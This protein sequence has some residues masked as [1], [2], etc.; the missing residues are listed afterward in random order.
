[1]ADSVQASVAIGYL[2]IS[3]AFNMAAHAPAGA[4]EEEGTGLVDLSADVLA[5]LIKYLHARDVCMLRAT[6]SGLGGLDA[7]WGA[8]CSRDFPD[9]TPRAWLDAGAAAAGAPGA[10]PPAL[11]AADAALHLL[12]APQPHSF[13][14]L[15]PELLRASALVGMWTGP[16]SDGPR[17]TLF[18]CSWEADCVA[19]TQLAPS[20]CFRR[21]PPRRVLL[22]L[23]PGHAQHTFSVIDGAGGGAGA[24]ANRSCLVREQRAPP[25]RGGSARAEAAAAV[26]TGGGHSSSAGPLGSSPPSSFGFELLQFMQG[27]M[28][29]TGRSRAGRRSSGGGGAA[30]PPPVLHHLQHLPVPAPTRQHALAGLWSAMY[31]P[32]G[33]EV[34]RVEY[35][36]SGSAAVIK[37]TKVLGDPN[38][39]AGQV[40]WICSAAPLPQPWADEEAAVVSRRGW[41]ANMAEA[42]LHHWGHDLGAEGGGDAAEPLGQPQQPQQQQQQQQQHGQQHPGDGQAAQGPQ[43]DEPAAAAVAAAVAEAAAAAEAAADRR[44]QKRVVACHKGQGRVAGAGFTN[45]AWVDGR[46]F[47]Y[48]DGT[49]GFLWTDD[50]GFLI[51]LERLDGC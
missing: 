1:M 34:L 27:T 10:P 40:S 24:A 11:G 17:G 46:L 13:R 16:L 26:A 23:G 51:D 3:A 37:A 30:P 38:V 48:D 6:H 5:H 45:P 43:A 4:I 35:D 19:V 28:A 20:K 18:R 41:F 31:G 49:C 42:A 7:F 33:L 22:R 2:D 47:V 50:Y 39:P 29:Q 9:T 8:L 32:H 36:F 15:Y 21:A 12:G 14:D 44:R 25:R